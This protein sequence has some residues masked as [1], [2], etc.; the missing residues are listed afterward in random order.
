MSDECAVCYKSN[1]KAFCKLVCNHSF[2]DPCIKTWYRNNPSCP[3]CRTKIKN[4]KWDYEY[5]TSIF[6][7]KFNEL[8]N[9]NPINL[10]K[11]QELQIALHFALLGNKID[12]VKY[13]HLYPKWHKYIKQFI[14][15]QNKKKKIH[16]QLTIEKKIAIGDKHKKIAIGDKHKKIAIENKL[17][18]MKLYYTSLN[19]L[20]QSIKAYIHYNICFLW[21]LLDQLA[22]RD[23]CFTVKHSKY[24][25][26]SKDKRSGYR[27]KEL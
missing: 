13:W 23:K 8:I 1:K 12:F 25:K 21:K 10:Y 27:S 11:V 16:T 5:I 6:D 3:M 20:E 17:N 4:K 18:E 9:E 7:E 14:I 19:N 22:R 15:T 24:S 26:P 2:C